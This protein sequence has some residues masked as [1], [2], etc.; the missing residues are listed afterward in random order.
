MWNIINN[1]INGNNSFIDT[2]KKLEKKLCEYIIEGVN[3][4][5]S[6]IKALFRMEYIRNKITNKE[7]VYQ[8]FVNPDFIWNIECLDTYDFSDFLTEG[9]SLEKVIEEIETQYDNE[10]KTVYGIYLFDSLTRDEIV[11]YFRSRYNIWF[12]PYTD[13]VVRKEDGPY[14]KTRRRVKDCS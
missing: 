4:I 5:M 6:D 10:C 8:K 12:Q 11:Q 13:W 2:E 14:E 9:K 7:N 3:Y 1:F